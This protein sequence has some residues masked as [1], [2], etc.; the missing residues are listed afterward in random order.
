MVPRCAGAARPRHNQRMESTKD[1]IAATAAR[2]VVEEGLDAGRPS[3]VP[4][5]SWGLDAYRAADNDA[6][7]RAVEE[8]IALFC[9][10]TQPQE[11]RVARKSR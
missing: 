11:L 8:Y 7:E 4:S 1:E 9:A 5:S 2:M 3:A 6:L 10:D